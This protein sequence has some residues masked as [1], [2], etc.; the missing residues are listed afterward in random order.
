MLKLISGGGNAYSLC[1][2]AAKFAVWSEPHS[3]Y[4]LKIPDPSFLQLF[5]CYTI[6]NTNTS[7]NI[8][9][10]IHIQTESEKFC[11]YLVKCIQAWGCHRHSSH[12][13]PHL[14][15]MPHS[16]DK[17]WLNQTCWNFHYPASKLDTSCWQH[18]QNRMKPCPSLPLTA[19]PW[20]C[21]IA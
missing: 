14:A 21:P 17:W 9:S 15:W 4:L 19:D 3:F 1:T 13:C 2:T 11:T 10:I 6:L 16:Y 20:Y 8:S 18:H 12:N 5:I 7:P